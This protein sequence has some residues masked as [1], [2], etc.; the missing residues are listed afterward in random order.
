MTKLERIAL[1]IEEYIKN[2]A[3]KH[4]DLIAAENT[5]DTIRRITLSNSSIYEDNKIYE[6]KIQQDSSIHQSIGF[7][8]TIDSAV[9]TIEKKA[10]YVDNKE[11][12]CIEGNNK[13]YLY[14]SDRIIKLINLT[15]VRQM[16]IKGIEKGRCVGIEGMEGYYYIVPHEF[17]GE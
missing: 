16:L 1:C 7:F 8:K 4:C 11:Y 13:E 14:P 12:R 9:S 15:E 17:K 3:E 2:T 5:I 10:V 6:V